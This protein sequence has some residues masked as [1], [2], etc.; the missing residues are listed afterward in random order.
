MLFVKIIIMLFLWFSSQVVVVVVGIV[1]IGVV[2]NNHSYN[3]DFTKQRYNTPYLRNV[4]SIHTSR[5]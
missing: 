5:C 4:I 1:V 3:K 2:N